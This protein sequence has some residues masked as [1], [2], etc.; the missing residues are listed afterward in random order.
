MGTNVDKQEPTFRVRNKQGTSRKKRR[1][2]DISGKQ[3]KQVGARLDIG[4][5]AVVGGNR[6]EQVET[7]LNKR[8]QAGTS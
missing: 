7:K 4:K 2:V 3:R 8:Q 5:Q 1:Q 6:R